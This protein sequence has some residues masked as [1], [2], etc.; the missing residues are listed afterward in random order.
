MYIY[1]EVVGERICILH[2]ILYRNITAMLDLCTRDAIMPCH[3]TSGGMVDLSPGGMFPWILQDVG[4][5]GHVCCL[6]HK[7][8][9][10]KLSL[11]SCCI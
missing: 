1:T 8:V 7:G 11:L 9:V 4:E 6:V 3:V 5:Q 10:V 2:V